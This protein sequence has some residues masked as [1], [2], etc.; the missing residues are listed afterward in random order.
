MIKKKD[1]KKYS[2][3]INDASENI[4]SLTRATHVAKLTHSKIKASSIYYKTTK[5]KEKLSYLT[6]SSLK[7]KTTDF[8]VEDAK[9]AYIVKFLELELNG[10]KLFTVLEEKKNDVLNPFS[11]SKD[12][13]SKWKESFSKALSPPDVTESDALAKQVYFPIVCNQDQ[14]DDKFH[15]LITMKSSSIAQVI[16]DKFKLVAKN[17]KNQHSE[18]INFP[19]KGMLFVTASNHQNVSSLNSTRGGGIYLF[20]SSPPLWKSKTTPPVNQKSFFDNKL[21]Y[22]VP[23]D[24]I[25]YLRDFLIR[26]DNINLSIKNPRR[27]KWLNDWLNRIIDAVFDRALLI[28]NL[29]P[30]WSMAEDSSLNKDHALFLDSYCKD[31]DFQAER[32]Q[33]IWQMTICKDFLIG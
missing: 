16:Y 13:L 17:T 15:L 7:H 6:T 14:T 19:G 32:K 27:A 5:K 30:G 23:K 12:E 21:R 1:K 25:E 4:S 22:N 31:D 29:D 2:E 3:W 11:E 26:F 10:E 9:F 8:A 18:K 33:N 24:D 20:K 28:Q